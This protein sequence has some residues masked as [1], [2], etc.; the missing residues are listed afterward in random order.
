MKIA[1]IVFGILYLGGA[2]AN[3]TLIVVNGPESSHGFA[4][5]ALLP[6]CREAWADVAIPSMTLVVGLLITYEV[7]LEL[8][9]LSS[10]RFLKIALIG[11]AI[12]CLV[13]VPFGIQVL[14]TNLPL[15]LIQIFLLWRELRQ[16]GSR[17][18]IQ[19]NP[20]DSQLTRSLH[21]PRLKRTMRKLLPGTFSATLTSRSSRGNV[22]AKTYPHQPFVELQSC[23]ICI[24][25]EIGVYNLP[26]LFR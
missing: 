19:G 10:R 13:T 25:A 6:F 17:K 15:G 11:G 7:A 4:D 21:H 16:S 8:L 1:R 20:R 26:A 9:F 14:S 18:P 22:A 3:I 23:L 12:F 5:N 2:I 24:Q